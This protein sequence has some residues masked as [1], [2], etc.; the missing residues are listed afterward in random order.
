MPHAHASGCSTPN[1]PYEASMAEI[2]V[3]STLPPGSI[4]PG[5]EQ[6]I[7]VHGACDVDRAGQ[8]I[9]ACYYGTGQEYPGY[10][11]VYETGVDG[12]GITLINDQGQRIKGGGILCD[13]RN[14]PLGYISGDGSNSFNFGV[15]L[16]LVKTADQVTSGTLQQAQTVFG[17]GIYGEEGIGSP[18][19]IAYA[20]NV[21][22]STVTCSLSPQN[23]AI[24][25]GDFPVSDFNGPG[26]TTP[27]RRFEIGITCNDTVQPELMVSSADG[28]ETDHPGV[29]KLTQENGV[30]SGVGIELTVDGM[31]ANFDQYVNTASEAF[32]NETLRVPLTACYYQTGATV[33]P[34]SAN[35]VATI[36]LAYK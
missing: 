5:T 21:N 36:T 32:S 1:I 11:G 22:F 9:I 2:R 7:Q 25:L 19:Q 3:S 30:A 34:G 15:T 16:A 13:T 26:S 18:N 23:F 6:N 17:I 12:I 33:E 28:Y 4:I 27:E 24:T 29:I 10:P 8:P 14:T 20:G 31:L 35:G